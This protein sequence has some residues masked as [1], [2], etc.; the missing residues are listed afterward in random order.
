MPSCCMSI[1][2][3]LSFKSSRD[4]IPMLSNQSVME[5][6][7]KNNDTSRLND[8][9]VILRIEKTGIYYESNKVKPRLIRTDIQNV[10]KSMLFSY[11]HGPGCL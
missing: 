10:Y 3:A 6:S 7:T 5:K 11:S 9:D 1:A 4:G 8:N 2:L